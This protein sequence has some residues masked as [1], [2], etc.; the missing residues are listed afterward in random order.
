MAAADQ[1]VFL[2][3]SFNDQ[4]MQLLRPPKPG[5]NLKNVY[6]TTF[7]M[8]DSD[9]STAAAQVAAWFNGQ[10]TVHFNHHLKC[11]DLFDEYSKTLTS[12]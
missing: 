10:A 7:G 5:P 12:V 4:N 9:V 6:A 8:S 2:G 11:S 1:I 3:F